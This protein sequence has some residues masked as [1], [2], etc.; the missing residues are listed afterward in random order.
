MSI[1]SGIKSFVG[2]IRKMR[3]KIS[4]FGKGS[5]I[6]RHCNISG[7]KTIT[8]GEKVTIRP[9]VD[10]WSNGKGIVIGDET[11]IGKGLRI[12]IKNSIDIGKEVLISPNVYI[13]DCD[14]RYDIIEVSVLKQGV[15][16]SNNTI[17][18][19]DG[20]FIGINTVIIGNISIGKHCVIGANSVVT[21]SVPE[22][23]VAVGNPAKVIK[24]YDFENRK[25]VRVNE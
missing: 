19:G 1:K 8:I 4:R 14:H 24:R 15:L 11:E 21:K 10:L 17:V 7:G 22:Y 25:W 3:F 16:E 13:T 12:S 9:F 6:G 5:Y 18:I 23:C 2:K 20:S